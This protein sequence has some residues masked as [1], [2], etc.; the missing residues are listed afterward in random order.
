MFKL[1]EG[2]GLGMGCMDGTCGAV[3][4]AVA[5][6]GMCN[7]TGNLNSIQIIPRNR[8]GFYGEKP[9]DCL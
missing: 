2:F 7:S 9:L 4:G 5:I 8:A 1:A 3:S 6:A